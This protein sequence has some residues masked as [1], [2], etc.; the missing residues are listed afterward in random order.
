[1]MKKWLHIKQGG[2]AG[3]QI[4]SDYFASHPPACPKHFYVTQQMSLQGVYSTLM[5]SESGKKSAQTGPLWNLVS[6]IINRFQTYHIK[7]GCFFKYTNTPTDSTI[8]QI[9]ALANQCF[10][11]CFAIQKKKHVVIRHDRDI[12]KQLY[13]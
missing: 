9:I 8:L 6:V 1:M 3:T 7:L 11:E 13:C 12:S 2:N 5:C 4:F 10:S